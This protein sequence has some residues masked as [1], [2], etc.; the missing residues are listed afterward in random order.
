MVAVGPGCGRP[1]DRASRRSAAVADRCALVGPGSALD[2]K[3]E[4]QLVGGDERGLRRAPRMEPD[5]VQPVR[6]ADADDPL[7][8]LDVGGRIAGEGKDAAFQRAAQEDRPAVE[9]NWVPSVPMLRRPMVNVVRPCTVCRPRSRP[10]DGQTRALV[11]T[12]PNRAGCRLA[13]I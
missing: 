2:L 12:R 8:G 9:V 5:V 13:A 11:E 7:P 10:S 4:A 6:L 3:I 1:R